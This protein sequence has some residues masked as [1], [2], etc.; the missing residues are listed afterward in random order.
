MKPIDKY[1]IVIVSTTKPLHLNKK[2]HFPEGRKC[3]FR[4]DEMNVT[5]VIFYLAW[6]HSIGQR[7]TLHHWGAWHPLVHK[8]ITIRCRSVT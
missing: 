3:I 7:R 5:F 4:G 6:P 8:A 1:G 2:F